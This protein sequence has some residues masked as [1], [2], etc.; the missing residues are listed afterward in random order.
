MIILAKIEPI[1]ERPRKEAANAD[2]ALYREIPT[3]YFLYV[4]IVGPSDTANRAISLLPLAAPE[5]GWF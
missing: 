2:I 1:Q 5:P 3:A 4:E